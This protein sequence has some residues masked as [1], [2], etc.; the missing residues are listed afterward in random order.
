MRRPI[1]VATMFGVL[2]LL[3][4]MVI[5][6]LTPRELT[7]YMIAAAT[8]PTALAIGLCCY[9]QFPMINFTM[10]SATFWLVPAL[11]IEWISP[12]P[13]PSYIIG[14]ALV[15]ALVVGAVLRWCRYRSGES[16][17]ASAYDRSAR[18]SNPS[19]RPLPGDAERDDQASAPADQPP[20]RGTADRMGEI[21]ALAEAP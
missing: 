17:R 16:W 6:V 9:L 19:L 18:R 14:T 5:D 10:I 15:P 12:K 21:A 2:W 4:S 11:V 20:D 8:A 13:L 3:G 7:V 1:D